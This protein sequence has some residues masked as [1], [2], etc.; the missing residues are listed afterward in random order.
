MAFCSLLKLTP[1]AT[2]CL[3]VLQHAVFDF[4][5]GI[6][7]RVQQQVGV[8]FFNGQIARLE[9]QGH[10]FELFQVVALMPL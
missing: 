8:V 5:V 3:Q 2:T 1:T 4:P 6:I 10:R 7:K 9:K